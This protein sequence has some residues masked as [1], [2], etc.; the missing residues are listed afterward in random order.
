MAAWGTCTA[1]GAVSVRIDHADPPRVIL[2]KDCHER[3]KPSA[4]EEAA[5][6]FLEAWFLTRYDDP[7]GCGPYESAE[8]G[9]QYLAG[10]PYDCEEELCEF[11][12]GLFTRPFLER[13]AERICD[14]HNCYEWSGPWDN[15]E[16][17]KT[18]A[19]F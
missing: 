6:A 19:P 14:D 11:W 13:V 10:G 4:E 3:L 16:E 8:G 18:D 15:D 2:C 1:C 5:Y 7:A 17:E 9:Y 12:E